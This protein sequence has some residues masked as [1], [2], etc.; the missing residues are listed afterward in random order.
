[1]TIVEADTPLITTVT[2]IEQS[3]NTLHSYM[4]YVKLNKLVQL[5]IENYKF[6]NKVGIDKKY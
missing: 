6:K 2:L 4:L 5:Y 1:M 3:H